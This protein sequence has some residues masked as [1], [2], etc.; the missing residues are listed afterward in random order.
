MVADRDCVDKIG[1]QLKENI[2][3]TTDLEKFE[4]IMKRK[5]GVYKEQVVQ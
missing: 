2:H 1:L 3:I 4:K 5:T